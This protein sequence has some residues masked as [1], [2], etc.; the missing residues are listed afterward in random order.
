MKKILA[1]LLLTLPFFAVAQMKVSYGVYKN[2][3][4]CFWDNPATNNMVVI[5]QGSGEYAKSFIAGDLPYSSIN[6]VGFAK[7]AKGGKIFPFDILVAAS[8]KA[9]GVSGNPSQVYLMAGLSDLIKTFNPKKVIGTGYSYGGQLMAGFLFNSAFSGVNRHVG[10]EIFD[11]YIIMCGKIPGS[12]GTLNNK[13]VFVIHG[14]SDTAVPVSN[15]INIMNKYN[16]F[17]PSLPI[18]PDAKQVWRSSVMSYTLLDYP[19][20][21]ISK[22]HFILGGGHSSAWNWGYSSPEVFDFID[23][24]FKETIPPP[25][26]CPALLDTVNNTATFY[27]GSDTLKYL[28]NGRD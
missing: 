1:T 15:G 22:M 11:G 20:H 17:Q 24:I 18:F 13:P 16:G 23:Y 6:N 8:Y 3:P 10:S 7:D 2:I 26:Q 27:I 12:I 21:A 9:P 28:I 19:E 5:A 25:I 14:T 4:Y